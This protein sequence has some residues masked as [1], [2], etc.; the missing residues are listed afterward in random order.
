MARQNFDYWMKET[1]KGLETKFRQLNI[2]TDQQHLVHQV[3][4]P[5]N[6]HTH[7]IAI[8]DNDGGGESPVFECSSNTKRSDF[9]RAVNQISD[10]LYMAVKNNG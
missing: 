10:I 6:G 9:M 2:I 1:T 3:G 7:Y 8:R 4:S 5:S